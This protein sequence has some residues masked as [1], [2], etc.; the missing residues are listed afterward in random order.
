MAVDKQEEEN[1]AADLVVEG[2]Q[3][4]TWGEHVV[5]CGMPVKKV[6]SH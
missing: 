4:G 2:D 5:N 6:G 1:R 3:Y